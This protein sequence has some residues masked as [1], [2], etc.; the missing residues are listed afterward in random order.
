MYHTKGM[1]AN[2]EKSDRNEG[3]LLDIV[4]E[5]IKT[6]QPVSS[7]RLLKRYKYD[8]SSATLRNVMAE[9]EEAGFLHQP[10]TSAGRVPTHKAYRY[11]V[12]KVALGARKAPRA[13]KQED[14]LLREIHTEFNR[15]VKRSP[16]EAAHM[17]SHRLAEMT[18]AMAFAGFLSINRFYKEGLK[19]LLEEPEFLDPENIRNLVEY[20]ESLE[21]RIEKIYSAI[22]DD[23]RIYIG[24]RESEPFGLMAFDAE[25]PNH[26]KA[27]FGIVGPMRMPYE[28]NLRLLE[29]IKD[30]FQEF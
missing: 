30:L 2:L 3:I 22:Q 28:E 29:N 11:F 5:Y 8:V 10:H 20:A 16:D 21:G 12:D 27:V 24:E 1:S 25:F 7:G 15:A 18:N 26:E 9:L 17:L 6:A 13:E 4:E 23:V 14:A 19:F